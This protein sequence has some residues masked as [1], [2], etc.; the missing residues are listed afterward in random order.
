MLS[1]FTFLS[2]FLVFFSF[3]LF[4]FLQIWSRNS[5]KSKYAAND[6]KHIHFFGISLILALNLISY[7]SRELFSCKKSTFDVFPS[8]WTDLKSCKWALKNQAVYI[9]LFLFS[10]YLTLPKIPREKANK[11]IEKSFVMRL[12]SIFSIRLIN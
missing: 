11:L 12:W 7:R 6:I 8:I 5:R 4:S 9:M 1:F 2:F 10:F 3:F